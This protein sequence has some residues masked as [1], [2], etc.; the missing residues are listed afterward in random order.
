VKRITVSK[1]GKNWQAHYAKLGATMLCPVCNAYVYP[2]HTEHWKT[3]EFNPTHAT[4][5]GGLDNACD[6]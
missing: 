4:L 1:K 5:E 3:S 2:T 6:V